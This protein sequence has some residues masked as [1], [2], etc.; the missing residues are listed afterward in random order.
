MKVLARFAAFVACLFVSPDQANAE[1]VRFRFVPADACGAMAQVPAGPGGA[2]GEQLNGF[3]LRPQ[4][5]QGVM[6]PNQMVTFL[7]PFNGRNVTVPLTLPQGTPRLEYRTDRIVYNYG[8]YIVEARFIPDGSVDVV[9]NSG[10]LRRLV[11]D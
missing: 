11:V 10:F 8:G 7:H 9:Y 4:P 2:L 3:G 1:Y 6:R 5:Y